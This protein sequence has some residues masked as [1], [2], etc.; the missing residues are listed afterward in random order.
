MVSASS[1]RSTW[2]HKRR[3]WLTKDAYWNNV[4]LSAEQEVWYIHFNSFFSLF[5]HPTCVNKTVSW[6]S[7]KQGHAQNTLTIQLWVP[8]SQSESSGN[9]LR[10][11]ERQRAAFVWKAGGL[12]SKDSE[13]G[14]ALAS[15][16]RARSLAST[17]FILLWLPQMFMRGFPTSQL[18]AE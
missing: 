10:R 14:S 1:E 11:A 16:Q 2:K 9:L 3:K 17:T 4:L 18:L 6:D 15:D 12:M 13:G 5:T 7:E 8:G